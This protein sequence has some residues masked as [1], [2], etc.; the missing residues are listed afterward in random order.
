MT[1]L[2]ALPLWGGN[3]NASPWG[4]IY[5]APLWGGNDTA[6]LRDGHNTKKSNGGIS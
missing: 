1:G 6:S 4:E 2:P 3:H 5:N